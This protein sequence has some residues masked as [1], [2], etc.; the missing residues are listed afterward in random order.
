MLRLF[1]IRD[2]ATEAFMRPFAA[3]AP[4]AAIREFQDLAND[5]DHPIGQ[6][7]EDYTLFE[8][9]FFNE[10]SGE[11]EPLEQGPRSLGNG[12]TFVRQPIVEVPRAT[13]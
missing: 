6:H 2:G 3:Q 8:I 9:G 5:Q 11:L 12:L 7:P 13:A 1:T 10:A 4:G